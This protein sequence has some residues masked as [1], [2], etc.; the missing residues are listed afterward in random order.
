MMNCKEA[1]RSIEKDAEGRLSWWK[2]WELRFHLMMCGPCMQFRK[3]WNAIS[4]LLVSAPQ[5]ASLS[6]KDKEEIF[7]RLDREK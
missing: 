1:T 7:I 3:Q 4:R 5:E 2:R 6:R